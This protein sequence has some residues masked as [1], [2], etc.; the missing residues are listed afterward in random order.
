MSSENLKNNCE[1]KNIDEAARYGHIECLIYF[2]KLYE[3][4]SSVK[5]YNENT[6]LT[7]A[8]GGVYA[9]IDNCYEQN[10]DY[11]E[12]IGHVKCL[13]YLIKKKCKWHPLTVR[14]AIDSLSYEC[15]KCLHLNC[16]EIN[17]S[18]K[19]QKPIEDL[20]KDENIDKIKKCALYIIA[21]NLKN[22]NE[23]H[24]LFTDQINKKQN[25]NHYKNYHN[26]YFRFVCNDINNIIANYV[27]PSYK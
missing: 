6:F 10:Y 20:L 18:H 3:K 26:L 21:N 12:N 7:A 8:S 11:V 27:M 2:D 14:V 16:G 19:Y 1:C 17:C 13:E 15:L 23:H 5:K 9:F 22:N 25:L 24:F 4:D